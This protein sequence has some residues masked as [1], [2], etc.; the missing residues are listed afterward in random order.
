M[1]LIIGILMLALLASCTVSYQVSDV[2]SGTNRN[3]PKVV[4]AKLGK[5]H[6]YK[7]ESVYLNEKDQRM[8]FTFKSKIETAITDFECSSFKVSAVPVLRDGIVYMTDGKAE[9][10]KC[11]MLP[12]TDIVNLAKEL[13]FKNVEIETVK[14][15][16]MKKA[17]AKKIYIEGNEIKVSWGIF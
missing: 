8:H 16:G 1:K 14:L 7:L 12:V 15:E 13:F 3:L 17:L 10:I 5:L 2:I 4:D 11:G 9:D 6:T